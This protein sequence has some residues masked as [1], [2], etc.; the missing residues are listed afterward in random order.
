MSSPQ[1]LDQLR[2]PKHAS[3]AASKVCIHMC[4]HS[5]RARMRACMRACIQAFRRD[6][7]KR[8]SSMYTNTHV[9]QPYPVQCRPVLM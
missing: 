8:A 4:Q 2:L 5:A 7:C 6:A 9:G 1:N 3:S